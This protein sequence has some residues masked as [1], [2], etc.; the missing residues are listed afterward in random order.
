MERAGGAQLQRHT[1][2]EPGA[3]AQRRA[4]FRRA[5]P[6]H[7]A[8]SRAARDAR[9]R[10]HRR[11]GVLSHAG[12]EGQFA[13]HG[14]AQRPP[15]G[16]PAAA[17]VETHDTQSWSTAIRCRI[18]RIRSRSRS[19]RGSSIIRTFPTEDHR[20]PALRR[21][22]VARCAAV[23]DRNLREPGRHGALRAPPRGRCSFRFR[24]RRAATLRL[25]VK[26]SAGAL[27]VLGVWNW[28][29]RRQQKQTIAINGKRRRSK[30]WRAAD[31][32]GCSRRGATSN[33]STPCQR[34]LITPEMTK[35]DRRPADG[36]DVCAAPFHQ[37]HAA[38]R[39]PIASICAPTGT[40]R[41]RT[42]Q[43]NNPGTARAS[44][45]RSRSRSRTNSSY[46]GSSRLC[47]APGNRSDP[48][49]RFLPP[50]RVGKKVARVPR[51]PLPADRV[52]ARSDHEVPRVHAPGLLTD[53][54]RRRGANRGPHQG[55]RPE[56]ATGSHRPPRRP[57]RKS[58]TW[59]RLSAGCD[60]RDTE[61]E[62]SWRRGGGLRVY[63]NRP[64]NISGYGEMLAVVL[65]RGVVHRRSQRSAGRRAA[66]RTTSRNGATIRS[67]SAHSWPGVAPKA[68]QLPAGAH[69]AR[70]DG[71]WLPPSFAPAE[72]A[73][74]PPG[75]FP[76]TVLR[77]PNC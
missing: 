33:W 45:T 41:T 15:A 14:E 72:E 76:V 56:G 31:S 63:L 50:D 10:R 32:T 11:S 43:K 12:V 74:Q 49:G 77:I 40:S 68:R 75:P 6:D 26:P 25:S 4:S 42:V 22:E 54:E 9:R 70:S 18:C 61:Q 21:H 67:G 52:L 16:S 73:D 1:A 34:P 23:Q 24:K 19:R 39:A 53:D 47:P 36:A 20:D 62:S 71:K 3:D 59:C 30:S 27:K 66:R 64:W 51:H 37:L 57:L 29:T 28:L 55:R 48:C 5:Q 7:A 69:H 35:I 58:F 44:T 60:R 13:S 38:S 46:A 17:P 2:A 8:R 65:P